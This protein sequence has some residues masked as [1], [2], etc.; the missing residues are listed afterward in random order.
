MPDIS[1]IES[2]VSGRRRLARAAAAAWVALLAVGTGVA[3]YW[4]AAQ[5]RQ[6]VVEKVIDG[7]TL[8]LANGERVRL[9]GIDTPECHRS[10]KMQRDSARTKRD[11][12]VIAAQG[13]RARLYTRSLVEAK[14]VRLEF[15][16]ERRDRYRR[17]LAYVFLP[18]G[19]LVNGKLVADGYAAVYTMPPNVKYA[20]LLRRLQSDA[21][22]QER[23]LWNPAD[24]FPAVGAGSSGKSSAAAGR[25]LR[26]HREYTDGQ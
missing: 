9:L 5:Y 26:N 11:Q 7:D 21:R 23:G 8:L 10:G 2:G 22:A 17:L 20:E 13:A 12:T 15:D 19:T 25:A 3:T 16:V 6:I 1:K 4:N 18:D 24:G 14:A